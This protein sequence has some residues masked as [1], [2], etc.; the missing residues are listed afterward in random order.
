MLEKLLCVSENLQTETL[1]TETSFSSTLQF[2][3]WSLN[4]PS[5]G[6]QQVTAETTVLT[7]K[8]ASTHG[9]LV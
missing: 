1:N 7:P 5:K 8:P 2:R 3:K 4:E 6:S 9:N